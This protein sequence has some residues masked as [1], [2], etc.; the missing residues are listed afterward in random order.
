MKARDVMVTSVITVKP[1]TS[2]QEVARTFVD[3]HISGAPVLD[4]QGR[5]VGIVSE[6]DL[7][8]RREAGTE[9]TRS[10]WLHWLTR[11]ETLA[12]DYVK[13]H[14]LHVVDV[15]T[16]DVITAAPE[17]PLRQIARLLEKNRIKRV[18]IVEN[19][20]VVGIVSRANLVQAVASAANAAAMNVSDAGIRAKLIEHLERQPWADGSLVNITVTDGVVGMWGIVNSEAERRALRV[21]AESAPGVTA[22]DDHLVMRPFGT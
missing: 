1:D 8:H 14:A 21:A 17:A 18:P 15:M 3:R 10:W 20:K 7:L 19:G 22:V 13:E 6:G 12:G 11:R 2:I 16:R 9:K 4:D 5:L